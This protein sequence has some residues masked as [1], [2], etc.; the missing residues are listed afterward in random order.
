MKRTCLCLA[1]C[2]LAYAATYAIAYAIAYAAPAEIVCP[3]K[4]DPPPQ[5]DGGL[6]EWYANPV[7]ITIGGDQMAYSKAKWKGDEDLSGTMWFYWDENYLYAAAEIVDDRFNQTK[8]GN[9]MWYGDHLEFYIDMDWKPGIT[10]SFGKGQFQFG[11]SPG[12]LQNTGD[13]LLDLPPEVCV[14]L[15]LDLNAETVKI[16]ASKTEKG[17]AVEA[18]IPWKLLGVKPVKGMTLGVDFCISDTDNADS[19]D[20]MS[21]LVPGKWGG[22]KR[23]HLVPIRLGDSQGK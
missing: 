18:A 7:P 16:A 13:M 4:T 15:P 19:Q 9:G 14:A 20:T 21:S 5:M 2:C 12:N 17:Y 22:Q 23:E 3:L 6:N 11:F 1:L 10:G 8:T